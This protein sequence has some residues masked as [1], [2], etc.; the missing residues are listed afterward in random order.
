VQESLLKCEKGRAYGSIELDAP[1]RACR[2]Q[3]S[4]S[5]VYRTRDRLGK[6][7]LVRWSCKAKCRI[8]SVHA[9]KQG[10]SES[11]KISYQSIWIF[12]TSF[13]VL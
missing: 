3:N 4:K 5:V 7:V 2:E 10:H 11:V 13:A 12:T 6:A 1:F 9:K 8:K